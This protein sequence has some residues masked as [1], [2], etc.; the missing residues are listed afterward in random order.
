MPLAGGYV[1]AILVTK[2]DVSFWLSVLIF[3]L[4]LFF[5]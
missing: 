3:K 5:C 1:V 4:V 2:Y